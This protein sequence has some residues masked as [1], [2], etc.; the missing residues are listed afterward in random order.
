MLTGKGYKAFVKGTVISNTKQVLDRLGIQVAPLRLQSISEW[1]AANSANGRMLPISFEVERNELPPVIINHHI[2]PRFTRYYRRVIPEAFLVEIQNGGV[3]GRE[4]NLIISPDNVLLS[5]LSREFGAYGGKP[6]S[7]SKLIREQLRLPA[8]VHLTGTVA[9]ISTVGTANFHHW[10]YDSLPRLRLLQYFKKFDEIDWILLNHNNSSFQKESLLLLGVPAEKI[11]NPSETGV[12]Y[13]TADKL[14][15]PSLPS[16]LATVSPWVVDFLRSIYNPNA[17]KLPIADF[18]Y[19]SRKKVT[20][21]HIEN[22]GDFTSLISKYGFKEVFPENYSVSDLAKILAAAKVVLSV[23][24][25]GLSNLCFIS[26]NTT[27]IDILAPYHQ[28]P[29]YWMITNIRNSKYVGF[30]ADGEHPADN[31]DL[32]KLKIDEDLHLNLQEMERLLNTLTNE[33]ASVTKA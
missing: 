2:T 18:V 7:E 33:A 8:P 25:S 28:D 17:E 32:V 16:P 19:L 13:Y 4:T 31:V 26:P 14:I 24:G 12:E 20:T 9:V 22:L 1:L 29:Y 15:I 11:I 30:F 27:V 21:R 10:N 23:H 6:L 3:F 5:D